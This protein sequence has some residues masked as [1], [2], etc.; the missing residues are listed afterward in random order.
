MWHY[1]HPGCLLYLLGLDAVLSG[2]RP[3]LHRCHPDSYRLLYQ[4][5]GGNLRPC[6]RVLRSLSEAQQDAV[7]QRII[8]YDSGT[9]YQY[10]TEYLDCIAV[11]LHPR[12]RFYPQLRIRHDSGCCIRHNVFSVRCISYRLHVDKRQKEQWT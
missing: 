2:N 7:V 5:Q 3:D 8:E 12:W 11:Y 6:T 4:W 10:F 9:Y 1:H